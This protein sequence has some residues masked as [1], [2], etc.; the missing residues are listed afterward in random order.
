M[1]I[2]N[3]ISFESEKRNI[4][5]SFSISNGF[6]SSFISVIALSGTHLSTTIREKEITMWFAE[7]D[8]AV[9]GL[10]TYGFDITDIPWTIKGFDIEKEFILNVIDKALKK[11]G[12]ML[13]DFQPDEARMFEVLGKF[14]Q[15]IQMMLMKESIMNGKVGAISIHFLNHQ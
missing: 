14:K 12:W 5:E 1:K 3:H 10:G 11:T 4:N 6:T 15:L 2:S 9:C 7:H 13:L 8:Y